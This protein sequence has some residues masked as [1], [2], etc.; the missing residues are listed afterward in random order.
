MKENPDDPRTV[1]CDDC[2]APGGIR[3]DHRRQP[4]RGRLRPARWR[5]SSEQRLSGRGVR[6][7]PRSAEVRHVRALGLRARPRAHGGLDLRAAAS[8]RGDRVPA[9]D[10]QAAIRELQ[11]RESIA[12][13]RCGMTTLGDDTPPVV[14]H[15]LSCLTGS[16]NRLPPYPLR[17][18]SSH[19]A[20]SSA[21]SAFADREAR[22]GGQGFDRL[23]S[24]PRTSRSPG[25]A[26]RPRGRR[27]CAHRFTHGEEQVADL[28]LQRAMRVVDTGDASTPSLR[29]AGGW[30]P[31]ARAL[32]AAPPRT[33][34]DR[35]RGVGPVEADAGGA[36]LQPVRAVQ[37]G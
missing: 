21:R 4:A 10:A 11:S 37:G 1:L 16:A 6:L 5:A 20:S 36:L 28:Q 23:E 15:A 8:A 34:S 32:P 14:H 35:A 9:D 26:R 3:R 24:S 17:F 29:C 25:R 30:R 2:L 18:T 33:L 12:G 7:V 22:A 19:S 31:G 13:N 27:P